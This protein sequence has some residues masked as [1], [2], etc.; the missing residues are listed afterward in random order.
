MTS[1]LPGFR[2]VALGLSVTFLALWTSG[3]V[4]P[5][6]RAGSPSQIYH[7]TADGEEILAAA[8][9]QARRDGKRVLLNLGA[10]WCSDS[11][12]MVRLFRSDPAIRRQVQQHFVP[13][14]V[15]VN[16]KNGANRNQALAARF[17]DPLARG[18]PVLLVLDGEG[19][20]L[21]DDPAER[22]SDDAH[23]H[24]AEV[25]AYLRKWSR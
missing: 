15:D 3:C 11:Q 2:A 21:N 25:L 13:A 14:M 24:P 5:P 16:R 17:G 9:R 10:N 23:K 22:L 1:L 6:S 7:P 8:L 18:I 19:A 20:L 12:A 4:A